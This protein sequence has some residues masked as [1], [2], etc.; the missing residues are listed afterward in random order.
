[1]TSKTSRE[2]KPYNPPKLIEYGDLGRLIRGNPDG[3]GN[4]DGSGTKTQSFKTG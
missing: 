1:M 4:K 2:R 3:L